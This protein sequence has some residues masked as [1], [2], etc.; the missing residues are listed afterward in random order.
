MTNRDRWGKIKLYKI[1]TRC[2][3]F[4]YNFGYT[5][6]G[7]ELWL[8]IHHEDIMS[9]DVN[10]LDKIFNNPYVDAYFNVVRRSER[11]Y[12]SRKIVSICGTYSKSSLNKSD[13]IPFIKMAIDNAKLIEWNPGVFNEDITTN[14]HLL[15]D[16][17]LNSTV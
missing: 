16:K 8:Y 7:F 10:D 15:V 3:E 2:R 11:R 12:L 13:F 1:S 6:P 17:I 5:S 9:W 4:A 14:L